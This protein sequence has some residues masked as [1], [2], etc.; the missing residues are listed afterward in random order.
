MS[1]KIAGKSAAVISALGVAWQVTSAEPAKAAFIANLSTGVIVDSASTTYTP[2]STGTCYSSFSANNEVWLLLSPVY[3]Y[4][5][6]STYNSPPLAFVI[7]RNATTTAV[8]DGA[9]K[10]FSN[11]SFF[12]HTT[13][14]CSLPAN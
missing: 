12:D 6:D 1:R 3:Y 9:Y 5:Q 14:A 7:L 13:P 2:V 4:K 8:T 10:Q 11:L